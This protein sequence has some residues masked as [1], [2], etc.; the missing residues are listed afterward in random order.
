MT[1]IAIK[2]VQKQVEHCCG[3]GDRVLD[4]ALRR[5]LNGEQVPNEEKI[6]SVFETHTDLIRRGKTLKPVEFG[7]KVYIARV[8]RQKLDSVK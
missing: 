4:Q 5:V 2:A 6:F 8:L 1:E 3:L 7:H